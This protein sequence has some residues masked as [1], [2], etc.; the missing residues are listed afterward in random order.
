MI[1]LEQK[2][3]AEEIDRLLSYKEAATY[4]GFSVSFVK[5]LKRIQEEGGRG[6][7][8]AKIG[9]SVRFRKSD[10]DAWVEQQTKR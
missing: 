1:E 9:H 10:I 8:F 3:K 5:R 4:T 6:I 7:P 2:A